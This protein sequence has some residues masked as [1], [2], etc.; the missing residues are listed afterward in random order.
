MANIFSN[1]GVS[2]NGIRQNRQQEKKDR[3]SR[4]IATTFLSE[5]F[6]GVE[7]PFSQ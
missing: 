2:A 6:L 1:Q 7:V 3:S 5:R 4:L